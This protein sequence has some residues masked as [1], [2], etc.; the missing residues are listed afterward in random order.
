MALTGSRGQH[1][2]PGHLSCTLVALT[3][4]GAGIEVPTLFPGCNHSRF[5][6]ADLHF[7]ERKMP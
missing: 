5:H 3:A 1:R 7:R 4:H 2:T 6:S